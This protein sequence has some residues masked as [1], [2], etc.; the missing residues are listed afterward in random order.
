MLRHA[1]RQA[2][3]R[4][5]S[6]GWIAWVRTRLA[7]VSL[8]GWAVLACAI[9]AALIAQWFGWVEAYALAIFALLLL[10]VAAVWV[11]VPS[12][13][14]VKVRL[15]QSRIVAGQSA[16][17]EVRVRNTRHR[18]SA[19]GVVELPVGSSAV[20][21][22][23]PPLRGQQE[24]EEIFSVE[25]RKRGV[26]TIGPPRT[27]RT[28]ALGLLRRLRQ[29]SHAQRLHVHPKTIRVPFDATGALVDVEGVTTARLSSSDVSFHAL[30]DY[31]PGDDRRNV[32]WP[33]TARTGRLVV[34]VFEETRRSHH[35]I[36]LDT[37][38]EHWAGEDFELAVSVAA[39]LGLSGFTASRKISFATSQ[40]WIS[41]S[42]PMRMLDE[43]AELEVRIGAS[44]RRRLRE[45]ITARPDISVLTL[46]VGP[47]TTDEEIARLNAVIGAN[48]VCGVLRIAPGT[49]MR[50]HRLGAVSV[51]DCPSLD[52]LGR[53]VALGALS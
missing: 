7:W 33:T 11:F 53:I 48:I 8:T 12:P 25:A 2:G 41:T 23:V 13:H 45:V 27:V 36:M 9:L 19:T 16:M 15:P 30:R 3:D 31:V 14:A 42:S 39:S 21:F 44:L 51:V 6:I 43:L 47:L 17:G 52:H 29:W 4:I 26:I 38:V 28:D 20:G 50:R 35:L 22:I 24:W 40:G 37:R 1:L 49:A 10:L 18:R 34:R 46:V 32:H 5:V